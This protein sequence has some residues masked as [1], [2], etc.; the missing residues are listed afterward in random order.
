MFNKNKKVDKNKMDLEKCK[1]IFENCIKDDNE[2]KKIVTTLYNEINLKYEELLKK[3]KLNIKLERLRIEKSIGKYRVK[4]KENNEF[5]RMIG[6]IIITNIFTVA[7]RYIENFYGA[8]IGFVVVIG[9]IFLLI[10][11][12]EKDREKEFDREIDLVNYISILVLE[13]LEIKY[14][15]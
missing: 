7:S 13:E 11:S 9:S 2:D 12:L 3:N 14:F 8:S 1:E 5:Y 15:K 10:K 4:T 6:A